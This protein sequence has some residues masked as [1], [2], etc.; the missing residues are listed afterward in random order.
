MNLAA[1]TFLLNYRNN[2]FNQFPNSSQL[3]T[4]LEKQHFG[5][6]D[7]VFKNHYSKQN[8]LFLSI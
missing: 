4:R 8:L 1:S 2:I 5:G 7:A 3:I 6:P